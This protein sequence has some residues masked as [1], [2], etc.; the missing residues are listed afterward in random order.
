MVTLDATATK[1]SLT[2]GYFLSPD[3]A[4]MLYKAIITMQE[5]KVD[6]RT[7]YLPQSVRIWCLSVVCKH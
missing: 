4:L 3:L 7:I 1:L 6:T 5:G 2:L